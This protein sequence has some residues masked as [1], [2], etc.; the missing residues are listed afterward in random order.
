MRR[1]SA[2]TRSCPPEMHASARMA[3]F[4]VTRG[5][6]KNDRKAERSRK[7]RCCAQLPPET[8]QLS[9]G[10]S[11]FRSSR[12]HARC[13]S[14]SSSRHPLIETRTIDKEMKTHRSILSLSTISSV[15]G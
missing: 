4:S 10:H 13:E 5:R 8:L 1:K 9:R 14:S 15:V 6:T 3:N 7:K 2:K 11:V 12:V